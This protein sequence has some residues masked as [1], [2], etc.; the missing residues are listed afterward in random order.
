VAHGNVEIAEMLLTR[1]NPRTKVPDALDYSANLENSERW[2]G[3][4]MNSEESSVPRLVNQA[5]FLQIAASEGHVDMVRWLIGKGAQVDS[6]PRKE[7]CCWDV[8]GSALSYAAAAGRV[9]VV[10]LLL[11]LGADPCM[12]DEEGRTPMDL[13][14]MLGQQESKGAIEDLLRKRSRGREGG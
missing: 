1:L 7:C 14:A 6:M 4:E 10:R 13:N 11:E 3:P 5:G 12:K 2:Y 8:N 9:E